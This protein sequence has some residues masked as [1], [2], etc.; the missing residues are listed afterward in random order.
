MITVSIATY[1]Q[2]DFDKFFDE[3][4]F[5]GIE[6]SG[7]IKGLLADLENSVMESVEQEH[8]SEMEQAREE[9]FD[10]GR[11]VGFEEGELYGHESGFEEGYTAGWNDC[12]D[13]NLIQNH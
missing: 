10:E 2:N 13:D 3:C 4:K 11:E 1:V 9:S 6:V 8:T 7:K 12:V 5:Q